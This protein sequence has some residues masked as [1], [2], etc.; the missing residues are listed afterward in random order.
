MY[1]HFIKGRPVTGRT[2]QIRV[3]LQYLGYPIP[4]DPLYSGAVWNGLGKGGLT[5]EQISDV[6][7]HLLDNPD[8]ELL[9]ESSSA[10]LNDFDKALLSLGESISE[11][12]L[13]C[14]ECH[15]PLADPKVESMC[16]WLHSY[17]YEIDDLVFEAPLPEW[18]V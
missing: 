6:C 12:K 13:W 11:D 2:H 10:A 8:E 15:K 16:I 4:N 14:M 9:D 17:K 7:K 1:I 3:H 5:K 18:A